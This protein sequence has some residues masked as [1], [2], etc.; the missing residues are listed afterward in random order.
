MY[1]NR[2][3]QKEYPLT[4]IQ[5]N[6]YYIRNNIKFP[7]L[8][9]SIRHFPQLMDDS[10][11]Y[12]YYDVVDGER[13]DVV[14]YRLYKDVKYYWTFFVINDHLRLGPSVQWALSQ[15]EL[16]KKLNAEYDAK[17]LT[18]FD[19]TL[20]NKFDLGETVKGLITETTGT[21]WKVRP[22]FGQMI[23]TNVSGNGFSS[24]EAVIGLTSGDS[25][26]LNDT[27]NYLE[28]VYQ[29]RSNVDNSVVNYNVFFDTGEEYTDIYEQTFYEY[30]I[31]KNESLSRIKVLNNSEVRKFSEKY[32]DLM[33]KNR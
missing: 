14:S 1:F 27:V 15:R 25:I 31:E 16:N 28:A 2:L 4:L 11:Q 12:Q 33:R 13:P 21:L 19:D 3:P 5:D 32:F 17:V 30:E 20:I 7:D 6:T 26:V 18:T 8:F 29:Y 22:E 23:L 24:S 10:I 9:R